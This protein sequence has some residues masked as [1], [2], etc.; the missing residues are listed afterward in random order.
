MWEWDLLLRCIGVSLVAVSLF[1]SYFAKNHFK[2]QYV[3]PALLWG[4]WPH[5]SQMR[6]HNTKCLCILETACHQKHLEASLQPVL[7]LP[8]CL[9][10][11]HAWTTSCEYCTSQSSCARTASQAARLP[12]TARPTWNSTSPTCTCPRPISLLNISCTSGLRSGSPQRSEWGCKSNPMATSTYMT[13][14]SQT[15][16]IRRRA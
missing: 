5:L 13:T 10:A 1:H 16:K 9:S 6:E 2:D 7:P 14:R 3:Y 8:C 11:F 15:T 12:S 4:C